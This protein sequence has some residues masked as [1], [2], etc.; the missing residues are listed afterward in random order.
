MEL[1]HIKLEFVDRVDELQNVSRLIRIK[2]PRPR[3]IVVDSPAGMGKTR[4]L[5][6]VCRD[7]VRDAHRQQREWRI[8]WLD[9]RKH[10]PR[11]F[12]NKKDIIEEIARQICRD[13]K[14]SNIYNLISVADPDNQMLIQQAASIPM[15]DNIRQALLDLIADISPDV[16]AQI[17]DII[18]D[19]FKN[20]DIQES[21]QRGDFLSVPGLVGF[22]LD[23]GQQLPDQVLLIID[24]A[25]AIT[26]DGMRRWVV[27]DLALGLG[28]HRGVQNAFKRFAVIVSGR[29]IE[30]DLDPSRKERDFQEIVLRSFTDK[31]GDV[32]DL[33]SQ[34]GDE[35][36]NTQ[37]EIVA[38]LARKLCQVC[39]GHPKVIKQTA[40]ELYAGRG[41]FSA[42][43]M[44][45]EG[46]AYWYDQDRFR[47]ALRQYRDTAI[48]EILEG[49]G[50]QERCLLRLLSVF[51]KFNP[52]TLEFLFRKIQEQRLLRFYDCFQ[53]DLRELYSNLQK[54]RLIGN[55]ELKDP[56]DSDRFS[57]N[58]LSA[59]MQDEDPEMFRL[60]NEWAVHLFANWAK[61][62][63]S[64][65]PNDQLQLSPLYQ[66][67]CVCEWL[68]HW[69]H[70]AECC[71]ELTDANLLGQQISKEL[72]EILEDIVPHPFQ[73]AADQRQR[74]KRYVENDEQ[75]K[76]LIWE[77]ALE[78]RARHNTIRD[79]ILRAF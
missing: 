13:T 3:V 17:G 65:D 50:D 45:P 56:F 73:S 42:L 47:K 34:F 53:G 62:R 11:Q 55:D 67:I 25:D 24:G 74:I 9:F 1:N 76:H 59:Q 38:R 26:D 21:R 49:V 12:S 44:E 30:Q 43:D 8:V 52:A 77:I 41:H 10:F 68:F 33:I 79:K 14:W 7:L 37:N 15:E 70:L 78:G 16:L 75:I 23:V 40:A 29:F 69:L 31:S 27:N 46:I 60:L 54:T 5:F 51:R 35:A 18:A 61:G 28:L 32:G 19:A 64:D 20:A 6:Q 36:F 57:L 58:L 2:P 66:Q 71:S 63:F 39:G 72:E 48:S 22:V 4:L